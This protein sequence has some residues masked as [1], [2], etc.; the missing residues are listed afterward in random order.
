VGEST[1]YQ[2]VYGKSTDNAGVVGESVNLH[3][4]Y[5]VCGNPHGAGV[6]GTNTEVGGFGVQGFNPLGDGVTGTGRRG[7]VGQSDT[8]QGV[9]GSSRD[10]AGVVGESVNQYG[11]YG[12]CH[13][14][15]GGGIFGTSD[16]GGAGVIGLSPGGE[17]V[18]GET[19]AASGAIAGV[20]GL[21]N[22][23][24]PGVF[25]K[26]TGNAG[27]IG[28]HGN[29]QLQE[30]RVAEDF[31][32]PAG[33]FGASDIGSGVVGYA[34][35]TAVAAIHG[36]AGV[37]PAGSGL[38]GLFDGSLQV[39]GDIFVPGAD[40]A[41]HFDIAAGEHVEPGT[42]VVIHEDGTLRPSETAYDR[43]VAGV[44][45]GAGN[46]RAG[47]VLDNQQS[48]NHRQPVAL[49][50]KVFCKADAS[51]APIAVGDLLTS[52]PTSGHA[53]KADDPQK[54][55]GAVLGKSLDNLDS[56]T[57]LVRILVCLQ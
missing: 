36:I 17:G 25:G 3:G 26:G 43:T 19:S 42:V 49:V 9:Y 53:M 11:V 45:S 57:G 40:C 35:T 47:L 24:G 5:G 41:E 18:H 31:G 55:F 27:V 34:R 39:N 44:I 1:S 37:G 52:S 10:N 14:P 56:G 7:V 50:G 21:S 46:Y 20:L 30:N 54:A 33:V 22:G 32:A 51:Y 6:Y 12:L 4:V 28:F 38:A 48:E 13:N 16:K 29:P 23:L 2:G 8:Y 15:N